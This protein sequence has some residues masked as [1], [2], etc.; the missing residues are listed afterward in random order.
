MNTPS[1]AYLAVRLALLYRLS[2]AEGTL[3]MRLHAI[4]W[5]TAF[6]GCGAI[7]A[8]VLRGSPAAIVIMFCSG[9]FVAGTLS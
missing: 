7:A 6:M 2:D 8:F 5:S 1:A 4:A 9:T 3:A